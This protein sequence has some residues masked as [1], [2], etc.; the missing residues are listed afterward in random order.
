VVS[1]Q[2]CQDGWV[3]RVGVVVLGVSN[4]QRP[5]EFWRQALGYNLRADGFASWATDFAQPT[6]LPG[7]ALALQTSETPVP[8]Y[9][10]LHLDPCT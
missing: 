2:R 7:A 5:A 10:R 4:V 1:G 9:P 6:G 8:D 3:L